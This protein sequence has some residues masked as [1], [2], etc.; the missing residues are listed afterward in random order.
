MATQGEDGAVGAFCRSWLVLLKFGQNCPF[1]S[2]EFF[3]WEIH[4][5]T[6]Q[7][8][9]WREIAFHGWGS[10]KKHREQKNP[11]KESHISGME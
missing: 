4:S 5:V 8:H 11:K 2:K 10:G 3:C 1:L 9:S 6:A 7:S